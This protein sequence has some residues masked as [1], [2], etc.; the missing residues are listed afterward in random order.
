MI[1]RANSW[2]EFNLCI[3]KMWPTLTS[4][5]ITFFSHLRTAFT[6]AT[7]AYPFWLLTRSRFSKGI[8]E[9]KGGWL[10]NSRTTQMQSI[11][12]S[13]QTFG[14]QGGWCSTLLNAKV[15]P[16]TIYSDGLRTN[17]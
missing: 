12:R 16:Q 7:S 17:F 11:S 4:S 10:Q 14:P 8:E 5:L 13:G 9:R 2:E 1:L 3:S 15:Q 6:L